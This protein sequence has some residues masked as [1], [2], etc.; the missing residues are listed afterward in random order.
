MEKGPPLAPGR[1]LDSQG[2]GTTGTPVA[3]HATAIRATSTS[4]FDNGKYKIESQSSFDTFG[5][6]AEVTPTVSTTVYTIDI[7]DDLTDTV[8]ATVTGSGT[9]SIEV[10]YGTILGTGLAI[11]QK[12]ELVTRVVSNTS[13]SFSLL[14]TNSVST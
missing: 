2:C 8:V 9:Q 13:I 14:I 12:K 4:L 3:A 6:A 5:Y 7:I 1:L 11:G 10:G